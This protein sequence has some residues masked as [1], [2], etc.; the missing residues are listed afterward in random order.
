MNIYWHKHVFIKAYINIFVN[1]GMATERS[2]L[3]THQRDCFKLSRH[4]YSEIALVK[5]YNQ[6]LYTLLFKYLLLLISMIKCAVILSL[7]IFHR[8]YNGAIMSAMACQITSLTI[9]CLT[10]YSRRRSKRTS[11]P[12]VTGLC[13]GNSPA[14]GEF[15]AQSASNAENVSIWWRHHGWIQ[16]RSALEVMPMHTAKSFICFRPVIYEV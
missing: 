13:E 7:V 8:H 11:K 4:L 1:C 5:S 12:R 6:L 16:F 2:Q 15:P 10:V 14:T 3:D 9:V